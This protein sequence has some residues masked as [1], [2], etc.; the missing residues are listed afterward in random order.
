MVELLPNWRTQ[1]K[2]I[3]MLSEEQGL[4]YGSY[5][6]AFFT[7]LLIFLMIIGVEIKKIKPPSVLVGFLLGGVISL[8]L[9]ISLLGLIRI[10]F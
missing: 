6:A 5:L 4:I 9:L 8:V 7:F 1:A 10:A 2:E 3:G